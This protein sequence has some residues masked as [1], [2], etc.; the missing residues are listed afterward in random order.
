[1]VRSSRQTGSLS[2]EEGVAGDAEASG[3]GMIPQL[4]G[5]R[6]DGCRLGR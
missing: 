6:R 4:F 5:G 3:K 1:M 2:A